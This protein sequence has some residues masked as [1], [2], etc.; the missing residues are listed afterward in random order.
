MV[1]ETSG[2]EFCGGCHTMAPMVAS[3]R[4]DELQQDLYKLEETYK[5]RIATGAIE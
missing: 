4:A 5:K 3:Y 1:E 2:V